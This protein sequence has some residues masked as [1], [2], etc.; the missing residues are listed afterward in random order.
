MIRTTSLKIFVAL[1]ISTAFI[2]LI[3]TSKGFLGRY[4]STFLATLGIF[5]GVYT[6]FSPGWYILD[7]V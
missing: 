2:I 3:T 1:F 6:D 4:E 5:G 7:Q